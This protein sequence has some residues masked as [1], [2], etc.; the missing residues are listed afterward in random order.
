[1]KSTKQYFVGPSLRSALLS[2][3]AFASTPDA[4]AW[5]FGVMIP[6]TETDREALLFSTHEVANAWL[7]ASQQAYTD[8]SIQ[9]LCGSLCNLTHRQNEWFQRPEVWDAMTLMLPIVSVS[10]VSST[11]R[12]VCS[13][14]CNLTSQ[15]PKCPPP[16]ELVSELLLKLL[17][18]I[19]TSDDM[20]CLVLQ[21]YQNIFDLHDGLSWLVAR[22]HLDTLVKVISAITS[23][24]AIAS[25]C[26][27]ASQLLSLIPVELRGE[28]AVPLRHVV[29]TVGPLANS[30]DSVRH[31]VQ[32]CHVACLNEFILSSF[33]SCGPCRMTMT[34]LGRCEGLSPSTAELLQ[35][36]VAAICR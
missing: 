7:L 32:L 14:V 5:L 2:W 6:F 33:Q 34:S 29:V 22:P 35:E 36:A 9:W 18:G 31:L 27:T 11:R 10:R 15:R 21:S 12:W 26:R 20:I 8:D 28:L 3:V 17:E 23:T 25:C 13:A 24:E 19:A 16:H 30:D 4:A 1:M